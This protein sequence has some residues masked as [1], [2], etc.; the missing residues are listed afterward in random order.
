MTRISPTLKAITAMP[1]SF[2][3]SLPAASIAA[4][5]A[6][7]QFGAASLALLRGGSC[8]NTNQTPRVK[9]YARP[10]NIIL[11]ELDKQT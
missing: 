11:A 9:L 6:G 10:V 5:A 8:R 7:W 3:T 2:H 1:A 4:N